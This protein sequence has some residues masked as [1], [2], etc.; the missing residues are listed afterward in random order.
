TSILLGGYPFMYAKLK[1]IM[2][3]FIIAFITAAIIFFPEQ[4]FEASIHGLHTWWE[5]V[6]PSLLPFFIMA[7]LLISFG[8]VQFFGVLFEPIM[9]P[10]F[11]VPGAGSF[12]WILGMVSGFPS[13][14]KITVLLR[15]KKEITHI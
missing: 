1:T 13:G 3:S 11:N 8:I 4:A 5:I 9:R 2:I 12:A 7:E 15:E 14:A 10:I 6:F